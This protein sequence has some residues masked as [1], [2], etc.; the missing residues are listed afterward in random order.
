MALHVIKRG[1]DLPI[2]GDPEQRIDGAARVSRVAVMAEDYPFM[3]PRMHVRVGDDV[4]LGQLL[5]EDRKTDGVRFTSPGAGKVEAINR[6]ERRALISV[7]VRLAG[8]DQVSFRHFSGDAPAS[9]NGETVRNLLAESG[10]WT[11]LRT[12]PFSKVPSPAESCHAVFVTA[13]DTNPGAPSPELVLQGRE[14]DWNAGLHA[15]GKL[16]EGRV[17]LC[18]AAG[19]SIGAGDAPRISLEQFKGPHPAGLAGT[20][21]HML[22][23]V[24]REITVFYLDYQDVLA[25]G[26]L[27]RTGEID[28]SRVIALSGPQATRPR[29][30]KTRL[31][32]AVDEIVQ[33]EVKAGENRVVSGSVIAGR[34]AAGEVNGYLGRYHSQIS[35]LA[36]DREQR[37]L[38]W[39]SPGGKIFST[40]N[41]FL[42]ALIPGKKFGFT[43][44]TN[45]SHRA[46]VPIGMYERV[47]P[48]DILPTY[49]LRALVMDD[50]ENAEALG[51]LELDED[52]LALCSMVCPGKEDYGVALR[53]NLT[54]VWKEG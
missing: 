5:F 3:K 23:P 50:L 19:S 13:M 2:T 12:R 48:L 22:D 18:T 32:A 35:V 36:E 21:I 25:I 10:L 45:G 51:C 24:N 30:L 46:M 49:L 6:G 52:D 38:G 8:N 14:A 26:H 11:A 33:G 15:V 47:M 40:V 20:H 41:V 54:Q 27:F 31:G 37:F 39:I 28:T 9:L 44:T 43:T 1:L 16:T 29:L 7:V 53:R 4:K 17:Y 34:S 42:S